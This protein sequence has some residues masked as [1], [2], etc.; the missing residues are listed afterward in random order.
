MSVYITWRMSEIAFGQARG[1]GGWFMPVAM[2]A[3]FATCGRM[4]VF[5]R[6]H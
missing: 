4:W 2:I 6:G 1:L 3:V 5:G